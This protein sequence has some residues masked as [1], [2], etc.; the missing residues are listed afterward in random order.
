V[1]DDAL[2]S[3]PQIDYQEN[4]DGIDGGTGAQISGGFDIQGAQD[5]ASVLQTGALPVDLEL[6]SQCASGGDLTQVDARFVC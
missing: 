1:L 3:V 2:I 4:P 5:L 6:I